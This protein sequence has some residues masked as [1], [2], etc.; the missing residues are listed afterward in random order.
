MCCPLYFSFV[1]DFKTVLYFHFFRVYFLSH[2]NMD[3]LMYVISFLISLPVSDH[4]GWRLQGAK[5]PGCQK[6]HPE[7][8]GRAGKT[9]FPVQK[10]L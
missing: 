1:Y 3:Y 8:D 7:D 6:A 5:S 2:N 4:A 10:D 9:L